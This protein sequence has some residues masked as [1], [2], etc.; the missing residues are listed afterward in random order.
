MCRIVMIAIGKYRG[1]AT[2]GFRAAGFSADP[3]TN[4]AAAALPPDAV[5]LAITTGGCSCDFY[6]GDVFPRTDPR[7]LQRRYER[8]GWSQAK[9][10]RALAARRE[11]TQ[12]RELTLAQ[13]FTAIVGGLTSDGA[14]ITLLAHD[15]RGSFDEPFEIT[16]STELPLTYYLRSQNEFPEDR[17]VSLIR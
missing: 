10:D 8:K 9:I 3:A 6:H 4:P 17:L 15:F 2:A 1:D 16:G 13:R 7:V 14:R 12:S 5:H 11:A